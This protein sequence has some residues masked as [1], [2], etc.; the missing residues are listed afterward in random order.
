MLVTRAWT[1]YYKNYNKRDFS[2]ESST[3]RY[4]KNSG[5]FACLQ[6]WGAHCFTDTLQYSPRKP[7]QS[8]Q[9]T[10]LTGPAKHCPSEVTQKNACTLSQRR[11]S[12]SSKGVIPKCL[13][14][15]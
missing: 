14:L 2:N 13:P 1:S 3:S 10:L 9:T 6:G 11:T 4:L 8:D 15:T 12:S 5:R 7:T